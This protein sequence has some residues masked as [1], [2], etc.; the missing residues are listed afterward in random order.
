MQFYPDGVVI[1]VYGSSEDAP[2]LRGM[3][4]VNYMG[5]IGYATTNESTSEEILAAEYQGSFETD[6]HLGNIGYAYK[7]ITEE[8]QTTTTRISNPMNQ[9]YGVVA[10]PMI[11]DRV[12]VGH[13]GGDKWI[14]MQVFPA[15]G[16]NE[17]P[18]H[19]EHDLSFI[20]RSGSSVRFNDGY[21]STQSGLPDGTFDGISGHMTLV[22]NRVMF[23]SGDKFLPHGL[24]SDFEVQG[25]N[26]DLN[27]GTTGGHSY[28]S[29]FDNTSE[30][31]ASSDPYYAPWD[32]SIGDKK[33]L[34]PPEISEGYA[35]VHEGGGLIQIQK[36][37]TNH[38]NMR[39]GARGVT[40]CAGQKYWN[41]GLQGDTTHDSPAPDSTVE[42]DVIKI[43]HHTGAYIEI[44]ANGAIS[45]VTADGQDYVITAT[46]VAGEIVLGS[47]GV[48]VVGDGDGTSTHIVVNAF[49]MTTYEAATGHTHVVNA[50]QDEVY[51]P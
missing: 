33:F 22:G 10:P 6:A 42:D 23:L 34:Q 3:V 43:L 25:V 5:Y 31:S 36:G 37:A 51:I 50:S 30:P 24:M 49:G 40:I 41:A 47:K 12:L 1:S 16:G 7:P 44:D 15:H 27:D 46:G 38:S 13:F 26:A 48:K 4:R 32:G 21:P 28:A 14:I 45:I 18:P 17:Q 39:F 11:G 20:H 8:V 19:D 2:E 35:V 29:I 9:Q